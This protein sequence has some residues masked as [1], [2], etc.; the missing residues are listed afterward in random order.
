MLN[1]NQGSVIIF[2]WRFE[3]TLRFTNIKRGC[4]YY[5]VRTYRHIYM[6]IIPQNQTVFLYLGP[7]MWLHTL[8]SHPP[9]S[10]HPFI[11]HEI[12]RWQKICYFP[13]TPFL[14][15]EIL[16]IHKMTWMEFLM[17]KCVI[18]LFINFFINT[19]IP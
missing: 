7:I 2:I 6:E 13:I 8:L 14:F 3:Y 15:N 10:L 1:I 9:P 12:P 19:L 5:N 4:I 17:W 11:L 18:S 16:V